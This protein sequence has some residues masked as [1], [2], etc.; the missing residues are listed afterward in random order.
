MPGVLYPCLI[1]GCVGYADRTAYCA[2]HRQTFEQQWGS[3]QA[4]GYDT[5]WLKVR[6]LKLQ[7]NPL[8]EDCLDH[9]KYVWAQE[10]HHLKPIER[11]PELRLNA[12]NLRSLCVGCHDKRTAKDVGSS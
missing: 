3:H 4:R 2:L 1:R 7:R 9:G 10:V 12:D 11:Y 8:C 5:Q 6:A